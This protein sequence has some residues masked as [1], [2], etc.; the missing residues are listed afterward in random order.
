MVA[1]PPGYEM[2]PSTI[3]S[4]MAQYWYLAPIVMLMLFAADIALTYLNTKGLATRYGLPLAASQELNNTI[5]KSWLKHGLKKGYV[6]AEV[7]LLL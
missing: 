2:F 1:L 6:I 3:S 5:R 7:K 4:L